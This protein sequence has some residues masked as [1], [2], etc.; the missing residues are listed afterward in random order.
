M[1]SMDYTFVGAQERPDHGPDMSRPWA[2]HVRPW[3]NS[4][5]VGEPLVRNHCVRDSGHA[6]VW[7]C[8]G[9]SRP[10]R[11][12]H[13]LRK[14]LLQGKRQPHLHTIRTLYG[15]FDT[16]ISGCKSCCTQESV[17]CCSELLE[18]SPSLLF[19]TRTIIFQVDCRLHGA[20]Q[21]MSQFLTPRH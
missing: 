17:C 13:C 15:Q 10:I 9:T 4:S 2:R 20:L 18:T 5:R 19:S 1:V 8:S 11:Y 14:V 21:P 12:K 16:N 3:P 6:S 7:S